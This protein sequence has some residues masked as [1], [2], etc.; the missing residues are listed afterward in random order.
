MLIS[1]NNEP[2]VAVTQP[3]YSGKRIIIAIDSSK[4]NSAIAVGDEFGELLDW[5][6]LNGSADGTTLEDTL[7]LCKE[8]RDILREIFRGSKPILVGIEDIITKNSKTGHQNG[9]TVH[10]SRFKITAV[11]MSFISFFQDEFNILPELVN[12]WSW[13]SAI[14]PEV[15][16]TTAYKKGSQAYLSGVNPKFIGCTDDVT[17]VVCILMYLKKI[18]KIETVY[19]VT[20]IEVKKREGVAVFVSNERAKNYKRIE[21]SYN[22]QLT[23]KQNVTFMLN[24]V[25]EGFVCSA[26]VDVEW[27]SLEDIYKL[28]VGTFDRENKYVTLLVQGR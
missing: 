20:G 4:T 8:E 12:N 24:R 7:R 19:P 27:L 16:R 6:E 17:D 26:I 15:Y 3:R 2:V 5:I 18:H 22:K 11:F 13:K 1:V 10:Q 9:M 25:K 28:A 21:F 14:L 23:L